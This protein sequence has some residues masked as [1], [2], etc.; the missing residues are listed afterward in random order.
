VSVYSLEKEISLGKQMAQ[1][2][3]RDAKIVGDPVVAE[4]ITRLEKDQG[5]AVAKV[6]STQPRRE[7]SVTR[8]RNISG[9]SPRKAGV[10]PDPST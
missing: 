2:V 7:A 6:F 3:E 9:N 4:Y 5:R 8:R 10:R 1:E